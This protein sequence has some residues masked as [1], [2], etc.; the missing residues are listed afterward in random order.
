MD[1]QKTT[2]ILGIGTSFLLA[3]INIGSSQLT[4]PIL[5]RFPAHIS[6]SFFSEFYTT[7]ALALVPL[8]ALSGICNGL[9]A[10]YSS[11]YYTPSSPSSAPAGSA[12][13]RHSPLNANNPPPVAVSSTSAL[14]GR[15]STGYAVAAG[16]TLSALVW[17]NFVMMKTNNR[18]VEL[19]RVIQQQQ[20]QQQTGKDDDATATTAGEVDEQEVVELLKRWQW[21]NMVRGGLALMG[22]A[23]SLL[24]FAGVL[25]A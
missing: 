16:L 18:L 7:G 19:D 23:V 12:Y 14:T 3:G 24:T 20:Q 1:V 10:Y 6:T 8:T 15:A 11:S 25:F 22:G 9:A 17:T 13:A 4:L 5:H 2:S 21:M